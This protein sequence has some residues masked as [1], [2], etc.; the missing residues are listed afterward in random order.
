MSER[1]TDVAFNRHEKNGDL[2]IEK[3]CISFLLK[4][5]TV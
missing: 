5:H 2:K 3:D 4:T 1:G